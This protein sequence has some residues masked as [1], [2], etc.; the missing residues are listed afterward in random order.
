FLAHNEGITII[1]QVKEVVSSWRTVFRNEA[2]MSARDIHT[3]ETCFSAAEA[4]ERVA[5]SI[6]ERNRAEA[7]AQQSQT[8]GASPDT[9]L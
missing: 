6:P 7:G 1:K 3:L 8:D 4:A 2:G 5:V 9:G